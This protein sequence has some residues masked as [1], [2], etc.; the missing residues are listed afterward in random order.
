[1]NTLTV[2]GERARQKAVD[3]LWLGNLM[4]ADAL[5]QKNLMDK[6]DKAYEHLAVIT[7]LPGKCAAENLPWSTCERLMNEERAKIT[8]IENSL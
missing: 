5:W 7:M 8:A 6:V 1:M 2:E 3:A 4:D